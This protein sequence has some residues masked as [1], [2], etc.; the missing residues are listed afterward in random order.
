MGEQLV[1]ERELLV[2]GVRARADAGHA[3]VHSGGRVRH[4]SHDRDPLGDPLFDV[5]RGDGGG[6]RDERLLRREVE[7]YL[8]EQ[9]VDVL[10]LDGDDDDAGA[11]DGSRVVGGRFRPISL[12]ELR[13][14]LLAPAGDDDLGGVP[15]A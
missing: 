5:R 15:P 10:R 13:E 1:G 4:R 14:P 6:D 12:A 9:D 8:P 7:A 2:A 3:L 11:A